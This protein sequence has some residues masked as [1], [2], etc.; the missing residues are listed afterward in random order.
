MYKHV[1]EYAS[2]KSG[3]IFAFLSQSELLKWTEELTK[4]FSETSVYD[5]AMDA[6][7]IKTHIG[8]G[9]HRFFDHGHGPIDAWG[10]VRDALPD[11]SFKDEVIGYATGLWKDAVTKMGLP[12]KTLDQESYNIWAEKISN[13][14]PLVDKSYLYD[15]LSYDALEIVATGIGAVSVIFCLNKQDR[16]RFSEIIASMGVV[17]IASANPIMA[18]FVI[19][20]SAYAYTVK[21]TKLDP[22]ALIKG[23]SVA[24][25][26]CSLFTI[27]SLNL[28]LE[29]LIV[30]CISSTLK[31]L[32]INHDVV[33]QIIINNA[34]N[35]KETGNL[36][37]SKVYENINNLRI[38][39]QSKL[40]TE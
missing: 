4:R 31:C 25:V 1:S 19:G 14:V 12:F 35:A 37:A 34:A 6:E 27:L 2:V 36:L 9:Y 24:A 3:S 11:D 16:Q 23:G 39:K 26:S 38:Q 10:K 8:G 17:S 33:L 18:I 15:L 5:K 28:F 22:K 29:L 30:I 40:L 7:Y 20:V 32:I 21:K 13:T